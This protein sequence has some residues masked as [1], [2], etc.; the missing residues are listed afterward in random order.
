MKKMV[1]ACERKTQT[2]LNRSEGSSNTG[3]FS[4]A[5]CNLLKVGSNGREQVLCRVLLH[6][7]KAASPVDSHMN[8]LSNF[9]W[10]LKLFQCVKTNRSVVM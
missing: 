7:V 10:L 1:I 5:L 3:V 9:Q 4:I 8:C 6:V 2:M